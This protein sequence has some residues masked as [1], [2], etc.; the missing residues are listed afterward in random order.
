MRKNKIAVILLSVVL[1]VAEINQICFAFSSVLDDVPEKQI[2]TT[3]TSVGTF[4]DKN[5]LRAF[6][7][8]NYLDIISENEKE[9]EENALVTRAYAVSAFAAMFAGSRANGTAETFSDVPQNHTYA[10]GIWQAL[11]FGIIDNSKSKFYPNKNVTYEDVATWALKALN[12]DIM[13]NDKQPLVAANEIGIFKG[14][15]R[16]GTTVTKGQFLRILENALNS[17]IVEMNMSGKGFTYRVDNKDTYLSKKYDVYLQEGVITGYK[18]SS[19]YGDIDLE[20]DKVQMNRATYGIDEELSVDYVGRS[21][22]AYVD[23]AKSNKIITL[24][25]PEGNNKI[26]E[27][28]KEETPTF[29][30]SSIKYTNSRRIDLNSGARVMYNNLF[31]GYY[32]T[33]SITNLKT[34]DRIVVIDNDGDNV[35]DVI[36]AY[37]YSHYYI[38]SISVSSGSVAFGNDGGAVSTDT[39][40]LEFF[41]DGKPVNSIADLKVNDVL[42]ALRGTRTSGEG[43][44]SAEISRDNVAEGV[45]TTIDTDDIGTY[46]AIDG[47]S[48]YLSDNLL[49]YMGTA[50][51]SAGDHIQAYISSDKKIVR[52]KMED[53]LSY[54]YLMDAKY[55]KK[56]E[57]LIL[58]VFN[59][60][61]SKEILTSST[62][63]IRLYNKSNQSGI[64]ITPEEAYDEFF[65]AN[66]SLKDIAI[67]YTLD[68]DGKLKKVM[69]EAS[70]SS[71]TE[72][73]PLRLDME[74]DPDDYTGQDEDGKENRSHVRAY[75]G[76]FDSEW[77]FDGTIPVITVPESTDLR[78]D[79][80]AYSKTTGNKWGNGEG[81]YLQSGEIIKA[82]NADKFNRPKFYT[83]KKAVSVKLSQS[84]GSVHF[85]VIDKIATVYD[86]EEDGLV[87]V[88][89]YYSGTQY[90]EVKIADDV[91][92]ARPGIFTDVTDVS[93]LK[94]GDIIQTHTNAVGDIDIL[95]VY[96]RISSP[97][98]TFGSYFCNTKNNTMELKNKISMED[99]SVIYGRIKDIDS[100]KALIELKVVEGVELKTRET[101]VT[102]GGYSSYGNPNY[103]L[104]DKT[105]N[106]SSPIT[107]ADIK[108]YD[109]VVMRKYYNHVQDVI[110]IKE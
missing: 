1:I 24:W 37:K 104:Y 20:P 19:M 67:A 29:D 23:I 2:L 71:V 66:G 68:S 77:T 6:K 21:I 81:S 87:R 59:V 54:G 49:S 11:Q 82:Y 42:T 14:I 50:V 47:V 70:A 53:D 65:D 27:V 25:E 40:T 4:S 26:Y 36:K 52:I 79:E 91:T 84:S 57:V 44:F 34:A 17:N 90:K 99:L 62:E 43:V 94:K 28:K 69:F 108:P 92:I 98:A 64:K 15:S 51:K 89:G 39:E 76:L 97:P 88:V 83:V 18:Y 73:Y 48:Y 96:F 46:Y 16:V 8:L 100:N 58:T 10:A 103:L 86:E 60:E 75:H 85:Y 61:G 33:A 22:Y 12:L 110:V 93:Q 38:T 63:K 41:L 7:L 95:T 106:T 9:F 55:K 35:G 105:K 13:L 101:T 78:K 107:L 56:D 3:E 74:R 80:K 109:I 5:V 102:I 72:S 31:D 45:I 30:A 32:T